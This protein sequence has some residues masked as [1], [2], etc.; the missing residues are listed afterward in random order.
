M[1]ALYAHDKGKDSHEQVRIHILVSQPQGQGR[2][3]NTA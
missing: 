1:N 3:E 2:P